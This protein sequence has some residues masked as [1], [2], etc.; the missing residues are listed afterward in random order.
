[1]AKIKGRKDRKDER[2]TLIVF[3]ILA[4][5]ITALIMMLW[6]NQRAQNYIE[7]PTNMV[8]TKYTG[9]SA[10][11]KFDLTD[12]RQVALLKTLQTNCKQL[13]IHNCM[14]SIDIFKT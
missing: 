12:Q 5:V 10:I 11:V 2:I 1:M 6:Y 13:D 4:V 3:V 14:N 9:D 8:G 7:I